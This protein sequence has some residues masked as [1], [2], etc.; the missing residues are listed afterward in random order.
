M[1]MQALIVTTKANNKIVKASLITCYRDFQQYC[2]CIVIHYLPTSNNNF[3][4]MITQHFGCQTL[5][6]SVRHNI[7]NVKKLCMQKIKQNPVLLYIV[8]YFN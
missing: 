7:S 2:S 3:L 4:F 5:V 8:Y 6:K 1:Y